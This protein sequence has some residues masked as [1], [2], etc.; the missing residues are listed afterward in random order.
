MPGT[1]SGI[2]YALPN[3]KVRSWAKT[4]ENLAEWIDANTLRRGD[5]INDAP[6]AEPHTHSIAEVQDLSSRLA[7][8]QAALDALKPGPWV[9]RP[10][11]S[12]WVAYSTDGSYYPGIRARRTAAG[13]QIQGMVKG[14]AANSEICTLPAE[15]VPEFGGHFPAISNSA[16]ATVFI[17]STG[18][19][20]YLSGG[21]G[22]S[23]VS[24]NLIVPLR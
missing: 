21:S 15:L 22:T 13:V 2:P 3:D 16:A 1:I 9:D 5:V 20:R 12:P 6:P 11:T 23:Y 14:G 18:Q 10:L 7:G 4:S 17:S 24:V 8:L 19:L